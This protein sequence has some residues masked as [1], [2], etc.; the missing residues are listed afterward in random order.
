[1]SDSDYHKFQ[2]MMDESIRKEEARQK[3]LR[4]KRAEKRAIKKAGGGKAIAKALMSS[5]TD[6]EYGANENAAPE[7]P[8]SGCMGSVK[9]TKCGKF[10][11]YCQE[12]EE[13]IKMLPT[14]D[15]AKSTRKGGLNWIKIDDLSTTPKEAKVLMV[16]Y[17]ENGQFGPSIMLKLAFDGEIRYL[18]MRPT[19]K[20]PRYKILLDSFGPDENNWV[21]QR[22]HL[23]AEK[24]EFSEQYQMRVA[25][26]Q[27]KKGK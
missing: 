11:G 20:D 12:T 8:H 7:T 4:A 21:D 9:C 6:F 13:K 3:I 25:L 2:E 24:D 19:K 5:D 26:P 1:M 16:R 10:L 15:T 22:I 23:L 18:S 14:G 27:G 17:N